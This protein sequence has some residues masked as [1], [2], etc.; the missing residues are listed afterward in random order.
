MDHSLST[1]PLKDHLVAVSLGQ[2]CFLK[3][4]PF[5]FYLF[6]IFWPCPV[7]RKRFTDQELNPRPWQWWYRVLTTAL[8][9]KSVG[10][11]EQSWNYTVHG[12][13][14]ARI[15][16]WVA[17]PFSRGSS[18]LRDKTQVSRV[19]GDSLPAEPHGKPTSR[20]TPLLLFWCLWRK[21]FNH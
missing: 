1:H 19:A 20:L 21:F 15:L 3:K 13:L 8:L 17:F 18:Q 14:Q 16:E 11:F 6:L 5:A 9:G 4:R 12:I 2:I 7:A 10:K